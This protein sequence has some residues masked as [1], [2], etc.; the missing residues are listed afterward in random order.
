MQC[1]EESN[2]VG[3][4]VLPTNSQSFHV[5]AW[6]HPESNSKPWIFQKQEN[7]T[8]EQIWK[9]DACLGMKKRGQQHWIRCKNA[10]LSTTLPIER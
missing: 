6:A 3:N 1:E 8:I 9:D 7:L 10:C 2:G 5:M 4:L